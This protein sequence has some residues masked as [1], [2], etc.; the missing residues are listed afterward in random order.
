MKASQ[1]YVSSVFYAARALGCAS[2]DSGNDTQSSTT[3]TS[4]TTSDSQSGTATSAPGSSTDE[5]VGESAPTMASVTTTAPATTSDGSSTGEACSFLNCDDMLG[6]QC[7]NFAQDCPEG[8]KCA[9]WA[10]DGSNSWN[11]VKCV[12]V[13][14][15]GTPGD[16][17]TT[18]GNLTGM[19]SCIEGVM[20]WNT[21]AEG[22]GTCIALCT[23][24]TEAPMCPKNTP[25]SIYAGGSLNLCLSFCDPL[26]QDCPGA[27][28]CIPNV[29]NFVCVVDA[30][31]EEGQANDPCEFANVC[32]PGLICLDPATGGAGCEQAAGG[33]CT[34]F[35]KFPDGA[36]PNPDQS[37]V[38]WF[39]PMML[40]ENDP[41]LDIGVCAVPS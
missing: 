14:G 36:C 16:D 19:D 31:G 21:N 38:Q 3:S 34:P 15:T 30:G 5:T 25:C 26:L 17:C 4:S 24:S 13:T 35:C 41:Q 20:C 27:D 7:D 1:V 22:I 40:P 10:D 32:D 37:C 8:Q 12:E 23:G 29:T 28:L 2:E 11:A 6:D 18:E 39:D 33:C 9:A